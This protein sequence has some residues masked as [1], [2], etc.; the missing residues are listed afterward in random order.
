VARAVVISR[1]PGSQPAH[2]RRVSMN[3]RAKDT[4][5]GSMVMPNHS[6]GESVLT[7]SQPGS[8][9]VVPDL[10]VD[11]TGTLGR[12]ALTPCLEIITPILECVDEIAT[13]YGYPAVAAIAL[14]KQLLAYPQDG[15]LRLLHYATSVALSELLHEA[16]LRPRAL[17]AQGFGEVAA[18]V[19]AGVFSIE[20]GA[21]AV[22]FLND[23]HAT[24]PCEGGSVA[25]TIDEIGARRLI[26][27]VG[28]SD[29][30]IAGTNTPRQTLIS[31]DEEALIS[32]ITR[33]SE[34]NVAT[35]RLPIPF[36]T[37]HPRLA[38]VA[39]D[40]W[41]ALR[42]LP[43]GAMATPVYSSA[44][45]RWYTPDEDF[46][47][48]VAESVTRPAHLSEALL[49]TADL[50]PDQ[51]IELGAGDIATRAV[52]AIFPGM[53]TKAPLDRDAAWLEERIAGR[54]PLPA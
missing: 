20:V 8:V 53:A 2:G 37:H 32:L 12:L 30:H 38:P 49:R 41:A 44:A 21:L 9:Y 1:I 3:E 40:L 28:P 14:G 46:A 54:H 23:A 13:D 25:V 16:G 7:V 48:V 31:G 18:L 4:S 24:H 17:V 34:K 50:Q 45:R 47:R 43:T 5:G 19:T 22:C 26:D 35:F 42:S 39:D 33:A 11:P 10:G 29:L 51:I 36:L 27:D 52:S 15:S 6:R